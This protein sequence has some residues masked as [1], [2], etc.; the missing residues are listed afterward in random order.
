MDNFV[1]ENET[2]LVQAGYMDYEGMINAFSMAEV[3]KGLLHNS[4]QMLAEVMQ[5]EKETGDF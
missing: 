4:E 1:T 2:R 3:V 5:I